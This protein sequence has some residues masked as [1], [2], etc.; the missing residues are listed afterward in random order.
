MNQRR[1]VSI[2]MTLKIQRKIMWFSFSRT[3]VQPVNM[4][5]HNI[6]GNMTNSTLRYH[7]MLLI[8]NKKSRASVMLLDR[9]TMTFQYPKLSVLDLVV[10]QINSTNT[11][12]FP[13]C[14][15]RCRCLMSLPRIILYSSS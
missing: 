6:V 4:Y 12:E 3:S 11:I 14:S 10:I 9:K 5:F 13:F 2:I 8:S 1:S 7:I 15:R